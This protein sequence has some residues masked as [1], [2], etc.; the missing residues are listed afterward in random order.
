MVSSRMLAL[1]LALLSAAC[2]P[3][4]DSPEKPSVPDEAAGGVWSGI[5]PEEVLHFV[6]TEPFWGGTVGLGTLR[7]ETPENPGG[8]DIV[9]ERFAGRG[10]LG[11]SGTLDDG[12]LE[13]A[14]SRGRCSDGM[15][16]RSYPF[17][18]T[19]RHAGQTLRGCGWTDAQR[20]S[21]PEAP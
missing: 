7:W 2:Q 10:G 12:A 11:F 6:G 4:V 21:G 15:S 13:M 5:G 1:S 9:V 18:V 14:V 20:F 3:G 16:D 17:V 8:T 19:V